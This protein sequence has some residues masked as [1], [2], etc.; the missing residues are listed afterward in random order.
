MQLSFVPL[1]HHELEREERAS[2]ARKEP[3][4]ALR[5]R[6]IHTNLRGAGPCWIGDAVR[7]SLTSKETREGSGYV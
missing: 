4:D 7:V 6:E 5:E 3:K 1:A 2:N